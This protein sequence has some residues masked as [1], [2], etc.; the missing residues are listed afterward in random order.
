MRLMRLMLRAAFAAALLTT[1]ADA[2]LLP[3]S[4]ARSIASSCKGRTVRVS[5]GS[6]TLVYR[7]PAF[8][9]AG[10]MP[11]DIAPTT[12]RGAPGYHAPELLPWNE[13]DRIEVR[14][15]HARSGSLGGLIA[16]GLLGLG[17]GM[18][19]SGDSFLGNGFSGGD[20]VLSIGLGAMTG[21]FVGALGGGMVP[22]WRIVYR[23]DG[24]RP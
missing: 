4:A 14:E 9:P 15:S 8:T 1:A 5:A 12:G 23:R 7:D 17:L 18:A 20:M 10:I 11:V 22:R 3:D 2:Q 19:I 24:G 13:V 21:A 16:G 6:R